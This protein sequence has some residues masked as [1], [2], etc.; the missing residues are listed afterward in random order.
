MGEPVPPIFVV[1][2]DGSVDL[3]VYFEVK[4]AEA[5]LEPI[6]VLN[7]EY[8]VYDVEGREVSAS[9]N[10]RRTVLA[11]TGRPARGELIDHLKKFFTGVGIAEPPQSDW[12]S[13][14][15]ASAQVIDTWEGRRRRRR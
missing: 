1:P 8:R 7:Q 6:D 11:A 4:D 15:Q 3:F 9:V 10:G 5:D 14:A 13:F 12:Y 2:T